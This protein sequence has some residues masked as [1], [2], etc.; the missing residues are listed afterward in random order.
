MQWCMQVGGELPG[1]D[2]ADSGCVGGRVMRG[3]HRPHFHELTNPCKVL[4]PLPFL[5]SCFNVLFT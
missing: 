1:G 4:G 3:L 2:G 5:N